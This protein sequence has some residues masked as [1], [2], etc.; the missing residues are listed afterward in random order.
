MIVVLADITLTGIPESSLQRYKHCET[1]ICVSYSTVVLLAHIRF[2]D[3]AQC[4]HIVTVLEWL[5]LRVGAY[6]TNRFCYSFQ[7][8]ESDVRR[9][10]R[11]LDI[12]IL[13]L[14]HSQY[15]SIRGA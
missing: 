15:D 2:D 5:S 10:S 4:V 12:D 1:S 6:P 14:E 13:Q 7:T 3:Y 8:N 9:I 11:S